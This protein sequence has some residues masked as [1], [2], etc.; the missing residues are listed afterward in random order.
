MNFFKTS[1][2]GVTKLV[3]WFYCFS[4]F[5]FFA[6]S[7]GKAEGNATNLNSTNIGVLRNI[8]I[9]VK[10]VLGQF[11]LL[12]FDGQLHQQEHHRLQRGD[13]N[14]SGTLAG[15]VFVKQVQG[16]G[17]LVDADELVST[18]QHIFGFLVRRR[19]LFLATVVSDDD[20]DIR[21]S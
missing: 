11:A 3:L 12:L 20:G 7:F 15:D 10:G 9:L 13:R 19:R 4:F 2:R 8:L 17:G 16:R 18:L 14:I 6:T 21:T 5:P 1:C